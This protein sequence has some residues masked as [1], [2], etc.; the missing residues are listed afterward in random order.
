MRTVAALSIALALSWTALAA[1]WQQTAPESPQASQAA[2]T[3]PA[4]AATQPEPQAAPQSDKPEKGSTSPASLPSS[5]HTKRRPHPQPPSSSAPRKVIVRQGG[6]NE[7]AEQIVPGVTP[8]EAARLR[9][10]A[11]QWLSSSE[12]QL[13]RLADRQLNSQ[14]QEG[15][16]QIRNYMGG[17][18][19][20]LQD[21]DVHRANTL[22]EKAH[23]LADDLVKQPSH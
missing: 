21:G 20:A 15:V 8:A 1:G 4:N 17:A 16:S 18:R 19:T 5:A 11:E 12:S 6:A 3:V 23:L 10:D 22:A 2:P 13:K 14:Q 9:Q 7:P